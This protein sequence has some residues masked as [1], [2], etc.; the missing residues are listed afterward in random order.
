MDPLKNLQTKVVQKAKEMGYLIYDGSILSEDLNNVP[1]AF[2]NSH[3]DEC[4]EKFLEIGAKG[5]ARVLYPG[6]FVFDETNIKRSLDSDEEILTDENITRDLGDKLMEHIGQLYMLEFSYFIGSVMHVWVSRQ[7]LWYSE[8]EEM[9]ADQTSPVRLRIQRIMERFEREQQRLME[10]LA[11]Q[12]ADHPGYKECKNKTQKLFLL[13]KIIE[14]DP[15]KF[16]NVVTGNR[17]FEEV[18]D[19]ADLVFRKVVF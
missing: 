11:Q 5:G 16:S 4:W 2:W 3:D 1:V 19:V 18:V 8:F 12:L 15:N 7:T 17:N 13:R 6:E 9:V 14:S 10:P